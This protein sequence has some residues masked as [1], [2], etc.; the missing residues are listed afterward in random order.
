MGQYS[1]GTWDRRKCDQ[2]SVPFVC[3]VSSL[4]FSILHYCIGSWPG[5]NGVGTGFYHP[6]SQSSG[7][8][9]SPCAGSAERLPRV[10]PIG[11][12]TF[13]FIRVR[14]RYDCLMFASLFFPFLSLVWFMQPR[15]SA[16]KEGDNVTAARD[17]GRVMAILYSRLATSL[18][19]LAI[20][21][22]YIYT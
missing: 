10:V 9:P 14:T 11:S 5:T 18:R 8:E 16:P 19:S 22:Q 13:D 3:F 7:G 6:Q 4:L 21:L 17:L 2:L 1:F 12:R 20:I 15:R